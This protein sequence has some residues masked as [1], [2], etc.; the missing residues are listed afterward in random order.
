MV[1]I[2]LHLSNRHEYYICQTR[3]FIEKYDVAYRRLI[4]IYE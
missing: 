1:N 3:I 2:K 4:S